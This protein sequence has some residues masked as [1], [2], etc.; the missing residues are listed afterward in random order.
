M[1]AIFGETS[2]VFVS[3][4]EF[5]FKLYIVNNSCWGA[6]FYINLSPQK[7][8]SWWMFVCLFVWPVSFTDHHKWLKECHVGD[9][10]AWD[11]KLRYVQSNC[12]LLLL[13]EHLQQ[14]VPK[15]VQPSCLHFPYVNCKLVNV[16][17][18]KIVLFLWSVLCTDH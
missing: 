18:A 13:V 6:F 10:W 1:I 11:L 17:R 14:S 7:T 4:S 2:T 8:V 12:P 9:A 15:P 16:T 3:C 5:S